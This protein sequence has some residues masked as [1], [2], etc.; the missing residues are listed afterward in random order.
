MQGTVERINRSTGHGTILAEDGRE[1]FFDVASLRG[2]AV[3]DV[4]L[5]MRVE[6][7]PRSGDDMIDSVIIFSA[8]EAAK[9][10]SVYEATKDTAVPSDQAKPPE[11]EH[12]D[13]VAEASWESFPASD[14]P[15]HSGVT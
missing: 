2:I 13:D 1:F 7:Q 9:P 14:P 10:A 6:F 12:G 5:G 8:E 4:K 15:A 11:I 3:E